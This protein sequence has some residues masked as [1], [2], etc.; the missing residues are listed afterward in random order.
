MVPFAIILFTL[1]NAL[2]AVCIATI[3]PQV[4]SNL[5]GM[6]L[7]PVMSGSSFAAFLVVTPLFGKVADHFGC[8]KAGFA[9]LGLFLGGA[10][11]CTIAPSMRAMICA[12]LLEGAGSAGLVNISSITIGKLVSRDSERAWRQ[13]ILSSVWAA[14]S[15]IGPLGAAYLASS[16]SW[17]LVFFM[18]VPIGIVA[19]IFW[20]RLQELHTKPLVRFDTVSVLLFIGM[21][22]LPFLATMRVF[23]D[24]SF[25]VAVAVTSS[26]LFFFFL[27]HSLHTA[28]PI[29]PLHLLKSPFLSYCLLLGLIT[30]FAL[31]VAHTLIALFLQG[32][33]GFSLEMTGFVIMAMSLGWMGGSFLASFLVG[34][35]GVSFAL[36]MGIVILA[37]G[38]A[39]L[40]WGG[41]VHSLPYFI[42]ASAIA[43]AGFGNC[44]NATIV[45]VQKAS[46]HHFLGRATSFLSLIRA[47]GGTLGAQC[48]GLLQLSIFERSL[49]TKS[50]LFSA[51]SLELLK[52]APEKAL[53]SG[54]IEQFSFL[55]VESLRGFFRASC[56]WVFALSLVLLVLVLIF[57]FVKAF[58]K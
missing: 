21:I 35:R 24:T 54:F 42:V 57:G 4:I 25:I 15:I 23:T 46:E 41:R 26:V 5:G 11:F 53:K 37:L 52:K 39:L 16:F 22:A 13:A 7:Y 43:G 17:R 31:M 1:M 6:E 38:F 40:A 36:R 12:R 14:A 45:G 20:A 9:A 19:A 28:S 33:F 47:L 50:T 10:L 2:D 56:E 58:R 18:N 34:W 49:E 8:R 29:V 48:G 32:G 3:M 30:G 55:E 27:R 51:A 44:I